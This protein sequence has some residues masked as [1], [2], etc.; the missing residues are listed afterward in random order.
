M[1]PEGIVSSAFPAVRKRLAEVGVTFDP[2]QDGAAMTALGCRADGKFAA[3]VGGV[4]WS[5]P[6]QV[7][8]T[9]TAGNLLIGLALTIPNLRVVWTSH[10]GRTT[11][12]TFRS[13][14]GMVRRRG[15]WK[16]VEA[17][18]TA[19]GEQEIRF[20]NGSIIMFGAREQ[21]FGRGMDAV[22][23]LVFDEAQILGIKAL[24]D[25]VPATNAARN[26]HGGL[27]FFIG[28]PP[29]PVDDGE[30][31]TQKRQRALD[32]ATDTFYVELSADPESD[33]DDRSQFSVMN[34]SHP[35][36]TPLESM[37]RM[38]ENVPDD[39]SWNREARG[40]WGRVA[41]QGVIPAPSWAEQED[42]QS[43]PV[44]DFALGVE[45]GPDLAWASVALAG[46]REDGA[47]HVELD[48]DRHT[49]GNGVAWL[50]PHLHSLV[51]A[52]PQ[53]R[54]VVADVAG[55]IR[56]LLMERG[57]RY[58]LKR[59]DGA[60][61]VEVTPMKV[62]ELGAGCSELLSGVVVGDVFHIGQPQ[63]TAA[64]LAATKRAIGD[65]GLW[66]WHRRGADSDITPI[67]AATYALIGTQKDK[68]PTPLRVGTSSSRGSRRHSTRRRASA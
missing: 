66:T 65:T 45:V 16:H 51:A 27:V 22:D 61:G 20:R 26:P 4:V 68:P 40:I 60:R 67:Q 46:R 6:R 32:G 54:A 17:I 53:V 18:R 63:L 31:F 41:S 21:G 47:W 43:I 58:W 2:W 30:A 15:I 48:D 39:D 8:K 12:N 10:H 34:P 38:R 52:N 1:I 44:D 13:M 37:L 11:T 49:K 33:P 57:G 25:M 19:N 28:T 42:P 3:T 62:S 23:V 56:P 50:E 35:H 14:Q 55:P 9:W 7:G 36:R 64:A 29:R 59:P 24:E 5:M